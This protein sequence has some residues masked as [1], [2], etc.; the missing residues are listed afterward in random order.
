MIKPRHQMLCLVLMCILAFSIAAGQSDDIVALRKAAEQGSANDQARLGHLY[1]K[2][3]GVPQ[4]YPRA[5]I[6]FR[7]AADQGNAAAQTFLGTMYMRG[8]GVPK[9]FTQAAAWLRKAA[10]QGDPVAQNNIGML[11]KGGLGVRQDFGEAI[12]WLRKAAD[13]GYATAQDNLGELYQNG[14]GV[15]QDYGQALAWYQKAADQG[16]VDA[17]GH[18][19]TLQA[20]EHRL[21]QT[22]APIAQSTDTTPHAISDHSTEVR[23]PQSLNPAALSES[24]DGP[25]LAETL[26]WMKSK[27]TDQLITTEVN[28]ILDPIG[29]LGDHRSGYMTIA[30][31]DLHASGCSFSFTKT[32]SLAGAWS[33]EKNGEINKVPIDLPLASLRVDAVEVSERQEMEVLPGT[34]KFKPPFWIVAFYPIVRGQSL[35]ATVAFSNKQLATRWS[36]ALIHAASLCGAI[37]QEPF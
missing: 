19:K 32:I 14:D 10:D 2:G 36:K 35:D 11:Y 6:W 28:W 16:Y 22:H 31:S 17:K 26:D 5:A 15:P 23:E 7:K 9:D 3:T 27:L 33:F 24:G 12:A 4:D 21:Q 13:Q 34:A 1:L 30:Y 29:G 8:Q 25:S 37:K 20:N 18:V